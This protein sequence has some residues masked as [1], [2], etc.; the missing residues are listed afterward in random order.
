MKVNLI[1]CLFV[2][3]SDR[4]DNI[5]KKDIKKIKVLIIKNNELPEIN[6]C[7]NDMKKQ[8]RKN[9]ST[10]IGTEVFHLE[11]VF[12]MDY[13]NSLDVLY[14][15]VTNIDNIKKLNDDYKL[16]EF[17]VENNNIVQFGDSVY[18]YETIELEGNNNI[19]YIHEIECSD[20]NIKRNILNLLISYK[21]IRSNID[22]TDIIFKFMGNSFVL[23]DV[24]M[25]YE[26]IKDSK[27]DKSNFRKKIKKYCEKID[28]KEDTKNGYRPSE[29]YRF[30]PLKGDI[31]L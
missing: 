17:K 18:K 30:K 15:G 9:I 26:I 14:L 21:K 23:E 6:F 13:E 16:I 19:E 2:L 3:D 28:E 22:T 8:V 29:K 11:Q 20:E 27:V 7:G 31:W 1:C 10:I 25:V 12:T 4:N 24:R 5:R